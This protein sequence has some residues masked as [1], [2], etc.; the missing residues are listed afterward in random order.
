MSTTTSLHW[1]RPSVT[2]SPLIDRWYAWNQLIPP[3]T[4][5]LNLVKRH[6]P[7]LISYL[8]S[9]EA[10]AA[11]LKNP[12]AY[13]APC[14]DPG[15]LT[16]DQAVT[17]VR[18]LSERMG[19]FDS[20]VAG[21]HDARALLAEAGNGGPLG[22]LYPRLPDSLRGLVELVYGED[23]HPRLRF[24]EA[25]L[26]RS[27]HYQRSAQRISLGLAP[28]LDQPFTF[29]SP[30][31]SGPG[32]INVDWEFSSPEIDALAASRLAPAEV[33]EL[34]ERAA[35]PTARDTRLFATLFCDQ[36]PPPWVPPGHG[37][38][39]MRYFGHA[40]VLL[41]SAGASVLIDPEIASAGDGHDHFTFADLPPRIDA[42]VLSH[43]HPDHVSVASL[44]QLRHRTT[45]VVVPRS[46]GGEI[47]DFSLGALVRALGFDDVAELAP[48]DTVRVAERASIQ[49]LPFLG[50]HGDLDVRAKMVPMVDIGGRRVIFGNDTVDLDPAMSRR[51]SREFTGIDALFMGLE[52]VGGSASWLYGALAGHDI[53]SSRVMAGS[54]A[55][56]ATRIV[57]AAEPKQVFCYALGLEPWLRHLTGTRSEDQARALA[58]V[59]RFTRACHETGR[60]AELLYGKA[61]RL[62]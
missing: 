4:A 54:D 40:G 6:K 36:P 1:L 9:P 17:A 11:V 19:A 27:E 49:A 21:I 61:E 8:E 10:H 37:L 2:L 12:G 52:C 31:L 55:A 25:L 50:E 32:R 41:E 39:R 14:L 42:I 15:D 7:I 59:D 26:Y 34:T 56:S 45:R 48:L 29:C 24:F 62:L 46:G 30:V 22:G 3:H 18:E 23:G 33:G 58:E 16:R 60:P 38:C 44:L 43:A 20:L 57:M 53:A 47:S 35:L 51:L 28:R 13:C 5:A